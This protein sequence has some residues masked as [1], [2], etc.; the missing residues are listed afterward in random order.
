[1]GNGERGMELWNY[2]IV[3]T[4]NGKWGNGEWGTGNGYRQQFRIVTFP[5]FH[6]PTISLWG[7]AKRHEKMVK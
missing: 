6:N 7:L 3:E 2:G 4:A 1:M 5:L